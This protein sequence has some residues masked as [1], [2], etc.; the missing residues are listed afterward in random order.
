LAFS[1]DAS[2][3]MI[4]QKDLPLTALLNISGDPKG[5]LISNLMVASQTSFPGYS[6][7]LP[8]D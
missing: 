1:L 2:A 5:I 8:A 6:T 4:P 7:R 3:T